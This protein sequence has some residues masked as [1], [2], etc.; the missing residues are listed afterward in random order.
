MDRREEPRSLQ[1]SPFSCLDPRQ[2]PLLR[3]KCLQNS[4]SDAVGLNQDTV[5]DDLT[6]VKVTNAKNSPHHGR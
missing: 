6:Y 5:K 3:L 1:G 2:I 4:P